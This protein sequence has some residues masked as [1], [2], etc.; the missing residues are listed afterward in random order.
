MLR[1]EWLDFSGSLGHSGI[2]RFSVDPNLPQTI[3][4]RYSNVLIENGCCWNLVKTEIRGGHQAQCFIERINQ[5]T[6]QYLNLGNKHYLRWGSKMAMK[7]GQP[8][9]AG[10]LNSVG[11][12]INKSSNDIRSCHELCR[13]FL[14]KYTFWGFLSSEQ[15]L[16]EIRQ[17][18]R[19]RLSVT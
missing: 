10:N 18:M 7:T 16:L 19:V 6:K 3:S 5:Q 14:R 1:K 15:W 2:A 13:S 11:R 12:E 17:D 9:M 8:T 4:K